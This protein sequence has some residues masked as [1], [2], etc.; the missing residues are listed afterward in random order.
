[1]HTPLKESEQN[2][3]FQKSTPVKA[4]NLSLKD[5]RRR[6]FCCWESA[7]QESGQIRQSNLYPVL[8]KEHWYLKCVMSGWISAQVEG[9]RWRW[10]HL[11]ARRQPWLHRPHRGTELRLVETCWLGLNTGLSDWSKRVHVTCILVSHWSIFRSSRKGGRSPK[12]GLGTSGSSRLRRRRRFPGLER[13]SGALRGGWTRRGLSAP[14]TPRASS[15]SSS[16]LFKKKFST[17]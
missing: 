9:V 1:M 11:G 14:P 16:R 12:P 10:Q 2:L 13:G 7:G 4:V 17:F 15:C 6:R 5:G 8:V 3:L